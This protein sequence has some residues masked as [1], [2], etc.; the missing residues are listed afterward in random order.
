[1][2]DIMNLFF[3]MQLKILQML[4]IVSEILGRTIRQIEDALLQ[5]KHGMIGETTL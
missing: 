2:K 1:V 4:M 3:D 5:Q